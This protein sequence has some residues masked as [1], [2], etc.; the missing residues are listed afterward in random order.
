M[1]G[2]DF[3][4]LT[5]RSNPDLATSISKILNVEVTC[6]ISSF[7]DGEVRVRIKPNIRRRKVFLIQPTSSPVNDY[8]MEL[9]LMADAAKRAS[10]SEITAVVP[11]FGYQRQDRKELSRVP[12]SA[13]VVSSMLVNAGIDRIVTV[14]IHSEH[15]EGSIREPWDN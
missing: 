13:A 15:M 6:P 7:A 9:I 12:I 4:L 8:I 14:D 10:A 11:Y 3:I 2:E 5:G 1:A